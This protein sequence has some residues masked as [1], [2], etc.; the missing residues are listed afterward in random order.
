MGKVIEMPEHVNKQKD[1]SPLRPGI[2]DVEITRR[3]N[4]RCRFCPRDHMENLGNMTAETFNNFLE[5]MPHHPNDT[6]FF[7]GLGEALLH[8]E[9][10]EY[11][12]RLRRRYPY[13]TVGIVTNGVLLNQKS[14][15]FLLDT[16]ITFIMVSFNGTDAAAYEYLMKGAKF[17]VTMANLEYTLAEIRRRKSPSKLMVTF[18]L[19]KEN[20]Q[21]KDKIAAFWAKKGIEVFPE[22]IH[23]RG[24]LVKLE[25]MTPIDNRPGIRNSC[26]VFKNHTFIA[27]N[28][29][30]LCC[31]H[32]IKNQFVMG[33]INSDSLFTI[34]ERKKEIIETKKWP[35]ICYNCTDQFRLLSP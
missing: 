2:F 14:V 5:K 9:L 11:M 35:S 26:F 23:T 19:S 31:C 10:S 4:V 20:I 21:D 22:F 6:V 25:G 1:V 13:F 34:N 3:C 16:H 33:N 7:C 29:D 30:V 15:P 18:L 28:G 32:D 27:W 8:P 24:G 17:E 12:S